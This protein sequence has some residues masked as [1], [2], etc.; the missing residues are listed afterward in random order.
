MHG[1][2]LTL[3]ISGRDGEIFACD[4]NHTTLLW[5]RGAVTPPRFQTNAK[6]C[7]CSDTA[8]EKHKMSMKC[9]NMRCTGGPTYYLLL[10]ACIATLAPKIPYHQHINL[11]LC[12]SPQDTA[13]AGCHV[14]LGVLLS[15]TAARKSM[16]EMRSAPATQSHLM[17]L[18]PDWTKLRSGNEHSP[19]LHCKG[20]Y[21]APHSPTTHQSLAETPTTEWH[22][23]WPTSPSVMC[24][25][26]VC[27]SCS[28]YTKI[29]NQGASEPRG[30]VIAERNIVL[31]LQ[32]W[33]TGTIRTA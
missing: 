18:H 15:E 26:P 32:Q 28:P 9:R 19:Q 23:K 7:C 17:Y 21:K 1:C 29:Q 12:P 27:Y 11:T 20:S 30:S 10:L 31:Q 14:R 33:W 5:G 2:H 8:S 25:S 6:S 4:T 3:K 13:K 16:Q 24:T 22:K